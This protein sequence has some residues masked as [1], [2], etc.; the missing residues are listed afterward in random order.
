MVLDPCFTPSL[1]RNSLVT[2]N[3]LDPDEVPRGFGVREKRCCLYGAEGAEG[4][5]VGGEV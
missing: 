4:Q 5:K 1:A 3:E 2:R